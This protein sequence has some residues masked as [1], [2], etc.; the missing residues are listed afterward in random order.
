M[1]RFVVARVRTFATAAAVAEPLTRA[2][3]AARRARLKLKIKALG[4]PLVT[5]PKHPASAYVLFWLQELE[6]DPE[7]K[8]GSAVLHSKTIAKRWHDLSEAHKEKLAPSQVFKQKAETARS[9]YYRA[10]ESYLR[11][12]T[13][14][15]VLIEEKAAQ[16]K[17]LIKP[18]K[19]GAR[20]VARDPNR[21][22]RP[23][24]AHQLFIREIFAAAPAE[25]KRV[26]GESLEGMAKDRLGK[27]SKA[28]GRMSKEAQEPYNTQSQKAFAAYRAQKDAYLAEIG[29]IDRRKA[30]E[31]VLRSAVAAERQ[32]KKEAAKMKKAP[33]KKKA[34]KEAV[35]KV[36]KK[37]AGKKTA[38]KKDGS[39]E[40]GC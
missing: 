5:R 24:T 32:K 15:D 31:K 21:P 26:L 35:K 3:E 29:A 10:Y 34:A 16:L 7:L 9:Q 1:N 18:P 8:K 11:L 27:V 20:K 28:W 12:R 14:T 19:K 17:K 2:A 13:P 4:T 33:A 25:Q 23:P 38:A 30:M 39:E 22:K 37:G 36:A 40:D 6:N